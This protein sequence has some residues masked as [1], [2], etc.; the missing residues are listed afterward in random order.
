MENL[1]MLN[2]TF[3]L[4]ILSKC[5]LIPHIP[6]ITMSHGELGNVKNDFLPSVK[7]NVA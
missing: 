5:K 2:M 7:F 1:V 6:Y 3:Y 4:N